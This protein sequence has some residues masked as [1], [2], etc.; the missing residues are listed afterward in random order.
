MR[1]D[2]DD[3][4]SSVTS[5]SNAIIS[6]DQSPSKIH[7]AENIGQDHPSCDDLPVQ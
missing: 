7:K 5:T 2:W 3:S 6:P 4:V 1:Y